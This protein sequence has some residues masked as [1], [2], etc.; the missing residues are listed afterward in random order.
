MEFSHQSTVI[1]H[2]LLVI[3][4]AETHSG[5][6]CNQMLTVLNLVQFNN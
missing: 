3:D 5:E 2:Q 4:S 1:S 6:S